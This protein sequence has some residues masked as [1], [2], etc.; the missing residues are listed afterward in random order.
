[1]N[2]RALEEE[3]AETLESILLRV[4]RS[5]QPK[6]NSRNVLFFYEKLLL[7]I[8]IKRFGSPAVK[9][10]CGLFCA[11]V[12]L[13]HVLKTSV[14]IFSGKNSLTLRTF[15]VVISEILLPI[16]LWT[17]LLK[18]RFSRDFCIYVEKR[19]VP[20]KS[21]K[22]Y[23]AALIVFVVIL[24][25]IIREIFK[26]EDDWITHLFPIKP[27]SSLFVKISKIILDCLTSFI[28]KS[29]FFIT[30]TLYITDAFFKSDFV[31]YFKRFGTMREGNANITRF[32]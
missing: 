7:L 22:C 3:V 29:V 5:V 23:I 15:L 6:K 10:T 20:I 26:T 16:L 13:A 4:D 25:T 27:D 31:I 18:K 8:G 19:I 9:L 14:Q 32:C 11:T 2:R 28:P 1:M 12:F 21:W 24:S 30:G 17:S